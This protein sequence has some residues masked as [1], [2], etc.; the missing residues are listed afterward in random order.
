[1]N[2]ERKLQKAKITLM[3]N[4][5]FAL[6]QG[7]MM[8]GKTTITDDPAIPTACTNGRD[9]LYARKFVADLPDAELAFVVAHEA[10]HKMYRHL[11]TWKKLHDENRQLANIAADHVVNLYLL[12]LDN[13]RSVIVMPK[14]RQGPL[15]GKPMG[16]ADPRFKGMNT[17]QVYDILK[18]EQK[19]KPGGRQGEG[20]GEGF[21]QHDWEGANGM[22]AEEKKELAREVDQAIRQGLI[23]Q[24]KQKGGAAGGLDRELAELLEPKLDW[25]EL[26]R[27]FVKSMCRAKDTSSWRRVNRRVLGDDIYLPSLIGEKIGS[28]V[29]GVDTSGSIGG[30]EL[31][32]FLSEVKSIAEEVHPER[33]DLLY[34]DGAVAGH[35]T[36]EG[37]AVELL[38]TS[39]KP[40]GG[41][42]TSPSCVSRYLK[43]K[44]LKPEVIVMLT[45]GYVGTDWGSEWTAP[46]MWVITQHKG[47]VAE[48]GKTIYL[49]K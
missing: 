14:H 40:V 20:E 42:G 2:S 5:K 18:Q 39:T 19:D 36:Y 3:R 41:G 4:S 37:G 12:E 43:D 1:M 10:M 44:N 25:R 11:T 35:E 31:V 45:D 33:V 26:L 24:Q 29:I 15:K 9:E 21:D 17:K 28:I 27:E 30:A 13:E 6:L 49:E 16:F 38:V 46:L 8:V 32:E 34:W 47:A 48:H 23:A 22:T 7:I